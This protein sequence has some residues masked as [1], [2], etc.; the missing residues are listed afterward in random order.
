M[1]IGYGTSH[2]AG[3]AVVDGRTGTPLFAASVERLTRRKNQAGSPLALT[4][5]AEAAIGQALQESVPL[6]LTN[7][8]LFPEADGF[9]GF[10]A[11]LHY[12]YR[13]TA[14]EAVIRPPE[15]ISCAGIVL[16]VIP[17]SSA[18]RR[19]S[20]EIF[21][22]GVRAGTIHNGRSCWALRAPAGAAPVREI[23]IRPTAVQKIPPD[24]R[25]LGLPVTSVA[26]LTSPPRTAAVEGRAASEVASA[27]SL[28]RL[29]RKQLFT[30]PR[31]NLRGH[32]PRRFLNHVK[33]FGGILRRG[34]RSEADRLLGTEAAPP[35]DSRYD[36]HLCHAASAWYPS[37]FDRALVVSLDGMGDWYSCRILRGENGHLEPLAAFYYE[38]MPIGLNYEIVTALLGFNPLRHAGKVTGLAAFGKENPDCDA[39]LNA[40][41]ERVWRRDR[42]AGLDYDL[43]LR[44][45][46]RG[47]E[48]LRALRET[49][50]GSFTREDLAY[51]IQKR[52][53]Q[54]VLDLVRPFRQAHPDLENVALAGGVFANVRVNQRVLELGFRRIFVQPAMSDA[55]LCLGAALLE[56]ARRRGGRLEPYRLE[57]VYLGPEF[58]GEAIREALERHGLEGEYVEEERIGAVIAG[59]IAARRVVAHF[60]GRMEFGPRAL[61]NRSILYSA[62]DPD[63]NRWLNDQ[64]NRTEFMPF[65]PAIL[66]ESAPDYFE[67]IDGAEHAA[68]FM[69]ITFHCTERARREIP[70]AIHVDNT[71]RPQFV[72]RETNPRFHAILS[73][74][75]DLTGVPCVI[76]TSFN[77]HEEPIVAT[78]A[79]AIRSFQEGNLDVLVLG[80]HLVRRTEAEGR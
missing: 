50:F 43:L 68:E 23:R 65:A 77:M 4:G 64:L 51:A 59:E 32:S 46:E 6:D 31:H 33:R 63:V 53:E 7:D 71:A 38:E 44:D 13:W 29:I 22:D 78:P 27:V 69:T 49:E 72:R 1:I 17:E 37:G 25:T 26:L 11:T 45:G 48:R 58:S 15:G 57:H 9:H 24:P 74:Y 14:E 28:L 19:Y 5:W 67:R 10:E 42:P 60:H 54:E 73:A 52:T 16:G 40:F 34:Y 80:N 66:A 41:L 8:S 75:R 3:L 39:A 20:A 12:A 47:L 2:D 79:D 21:L 36:H 56:C 35:L 18:M 30:L 76:N 62:A 70:A 61:G 55:G